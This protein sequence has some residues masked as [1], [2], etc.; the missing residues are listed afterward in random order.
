MKLLL[1]THAL[2][3]WDAEP[4]KLS[5]AVIG[6]LQDPSTLV[7]LSVINVWEIVIKNQIGKLSTP[8]TPT[9][10]V[11]RQSANGIIILPVTLEHVVVLEHLPPI[12]KDPFDRLLI[13]QAIAENASI[14]SADRVFDQYPVRVVW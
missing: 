11:E 1:D 10:I 2:V 12:H 4:E 9:Q 3:W 7:Y 14:L 8:R 5:T 6:L 13:C